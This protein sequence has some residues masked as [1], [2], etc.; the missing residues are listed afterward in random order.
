MLNNEEI[1]VESD[2]I[3]SGKIVE[4]R[5][6]TVVLPDGT[7]STRE[8]VSHAPAVVILPLLNEKEIIL[9]SQYRKVFE[10][11]LLEI[12]A[13]LINENEDPLDAAKRELREE[14][15]YRAMS[16]TSLGEYYP[17]PGFCN[18]VYH[19]YIARN[20]IPGSQDLD[21]DERV[22]VKILSVDKLRDLI[23]NN[24]IK[25]A[26]TVLAFYLGLNNFI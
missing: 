4:L 9:V 15:G 21:D 20:L 2:L 5:K 23:K 11:T 3:Y 26:K 8:L 19:V 22:A 10:K 12:P 17:T 13:G 1:T 24:S 6:D 14:T 16:W 25:D 18:E 7:M